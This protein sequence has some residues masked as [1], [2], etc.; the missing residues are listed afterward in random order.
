MSRWRVVDGAVGQLVCVTLVLAES[1]FA[2][3]DVWR[4]AA[5]LALAELCYLLGFGL[6]ALRE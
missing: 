6:G 3:G 5:H 4:F 1:W 2:G